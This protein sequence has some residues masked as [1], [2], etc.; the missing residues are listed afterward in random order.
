MY[1]SLGTAGGSLADL[2][3]WRL[4]RFGARHTARCTTCH[5]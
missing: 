1:T 5:G 3:Y 4:P 2:N